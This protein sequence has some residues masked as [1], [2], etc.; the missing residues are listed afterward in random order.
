MATLAEFPALTAALKQMGEDIGNNYADAIGRNGHD[1][2]KTLSNMARDVTL[3]Q[4][5][6][7]GDEMVLTFDLPSYWKYVE[8]GTRPHWPPR[9]PIAKWI[10]A[11][12]VIP[13]PGRNGR[14]PSPEQLNYL[15]RRKIAT[16]GT[17]VTH[18]LAQSIDTAIPFWER[19]IAEALAD[20]LPRIVL[21]DLST[22]FRDVYG[23]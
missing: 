15:I 10:E 8:E 12:P 11:K 18:E 2:T 4:I 3:H 19:R 21:Q 13:Y 9:E 6:V 23:S 22:L 7:E 1:T 16:E 5:V 20:D 14:L 17:I